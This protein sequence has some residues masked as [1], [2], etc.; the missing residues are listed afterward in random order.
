MDAL[1][2][3][4]ELRKIRKSPFFLVQRIIVLGIL[5]FIIFYFTAVS[6]DYELEASNTIPLVDLLSYEG[7][8]ALIIAAVYAAIVFM[9]FLGWNST[10]Y[11]ISPSSIKKSKG[12]LSRSE[13]GISIKNIE[14]V[15]SEE[16][17]FGKM[18]GYGSLLIKNKRGET[19]FILDNIEDPDKN[20]AIITD[21]MENV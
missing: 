6:F 18:L 13:Q 19:I 5:L 17:M 16:P 7:L 15:T 10:Y 3:K 12:I 11:E 20:K 14:L 9:M 8:I 4:P 1:K 2:P 21:L